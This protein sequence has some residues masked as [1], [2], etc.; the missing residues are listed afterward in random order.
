MSDKEK[1]KCYLKF[2]TY[3]MVREKILASV[4]KKIE[5]V[6]YH[7]DWDNVHKILDEIEVI[8][9]ILDKTDERFGLILKDDEDDQSSSE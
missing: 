2:D 8:L 3:L 6:L 5:Q 4:D 7:E 1:I 9:D